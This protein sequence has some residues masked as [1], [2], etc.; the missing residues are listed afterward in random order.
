ML[1]FCSGASSGESA[2]LLTLLTHSFVVVVLG[3]WRGHMLA[4]ETLREKVEIMVE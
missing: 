1:A 2:S 4:A 3:G